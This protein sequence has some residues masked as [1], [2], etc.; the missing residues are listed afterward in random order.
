[1]KTKTKP[2]LLLKVIVQHKENLKQ[3]LRVYELTIIDELQQ[4]VPAIELRKKNYS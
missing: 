3:Y 2:F 1:V 4:P